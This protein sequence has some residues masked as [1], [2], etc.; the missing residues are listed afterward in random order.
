MRQK[1][2]ALEETKVWIFGGFDPLNKCYYSDMWE[3]SCRAGQWTS[4]QVFNGRGDSIQPKPFVTNLSI[5]TGPRYD[6]LVVLHEPRGSQ[7]LSTA[8]TPWVFDNCSSVLRLE[9]FAPR[10]AMDTRLIE[11]AGAVLFGDEKKENLPIVSKVAE[12]NPILPAE[13][14]VV[15]E[16]ELAF[17]YGWSSRG[18]RR[19]DTVRYNA[20][21][22]TAEI[23][24]PAASCCVVLSKV[25]KILQGKRLKNGKFRE[26]DDDDLKKYV[27]SGGKPIFKSSLSLSQRHFLAH[28]GD[29]VAVATSPRNSIVATAQENPRGRIILWN[30]V[31]LQ[32]CG[33]I[34]DKE[35]NNVRHLSFSPEDGSKLLVL[36][37]PAPVAPF[38]VSIYDPKTNCS[39]KPFQFTWISIIVF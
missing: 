37:A 19:R 8:M 20:I 4:S 36:S 16:T 10:I 32:C 2:A 33:V 31:K 27:S 13:A 21:E 35:V 12:W 3:L 7:A 30:A 11:K 22:G 6:S 9:N 28:D 5:F 17:V 25:W 29:V 23:I 18:L 26:L 38:F 34:K 39:S 15:N 24:Y 1:T 14:Q